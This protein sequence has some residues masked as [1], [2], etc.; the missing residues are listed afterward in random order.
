MVWY[1]SCDRKPPA[2]L[3]VLVWEPENRNIYIAWWDGKKWWEWRPG[4]VPEK[5]LPFDPTYWCRTP[6]GPSKRSRK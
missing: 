3:S 4:E 5:R 2:A 1:R 6:R